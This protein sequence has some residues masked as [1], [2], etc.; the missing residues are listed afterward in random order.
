MMKPSE[1]LQQLNLTLPPVT[2]PVGAYVPALRHGD[3]LL[4][5]GQIPVREG[6]VAYAGK[7][8]GPAGRTLEDGRAAARLC[9]LNALA[10]AADAAGG[11]DRLARVLKVVVYVASNAGFTDQH[12]VANGA[13]DL[14]AEVF[15]EAGKH[16]RAAVGVAELPLN[17]T[18]EVDVT[19]GL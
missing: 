14:L 5:S 16:C 11:V 4:L 9:A 1:R 15:G 12:K 10:I 6:K 18:V 17:A 7:V 3:T 13:S 2:K 19:F 8:G